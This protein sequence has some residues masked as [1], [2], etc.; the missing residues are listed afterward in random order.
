M[1]A[2]TLAQLQKK[3][4]NIVQLH[5]TI[6][7]KIDT[8]TEFKEEIVNADTYQLTLEEQIAFLTE[9]IH[10]AS[11][12]QSITVSPPA[13]SPLTSAADYEHSNTTHMEPIHVSPSDTQTHTHT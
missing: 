2:T 7:A 8:K 10:K 12:L 6:T 9:F 4:E 13:V 5:A 11:L 3:Q 1:A